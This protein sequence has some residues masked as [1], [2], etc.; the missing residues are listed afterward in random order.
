MSGVIYSYN[1][2][3]TDDGEATMSR[4]E[5]VP[6]NSNRDN[7]TLLR[8]RMHVEGLMMAASQSALID[9]INDFIAA[10]SVNGAGDATITVNGLSTPHVISNN[11]LTGTRVAYRSWPKGD[12]VELLKVRTWSVVMESLEL[13]STQ[14]SQIEEYHDQVEVHGNGGPDW[15]YVQV[16]VGLPRLQIRSQA[17]PVS[18]VQSG[19]SLGLQGYVLPTGPIVAAL[20][21][22]R[23]YLLSRGT[24][25]RVGNS[26][27][28]YPM[29]WRYQ[30]TNSGFTDAAPVPK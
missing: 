2:Y 14:E 15:E 11:S 12:P 20:E 7:R 17:S 22:G 6:V 25:Q 21:Q 3:T 30:F 4:Y 23:G 8:H 16:S 28:H 10:H 18:I 13:T 19:A 1:G 5:V 24:P 27:L 26:F 29:R 9:R